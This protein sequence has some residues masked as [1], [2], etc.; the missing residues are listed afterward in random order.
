MKQNACEAIELTNLIRINIGMR[1]F[2]LPNT[3]N[4]VHFLLGKL[5][6]FI[7]VLIINLPPVQPVTRTKLVTNY[8]TVQLHHVNASIFCITLPDVQ[9]RF[10]HQTF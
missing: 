5:H 2:A 8:T 9:M 7:I 3:A 10:D 1:D 4:H 6:L